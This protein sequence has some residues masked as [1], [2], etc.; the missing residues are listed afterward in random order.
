MMKNYFI[1]T[2]LL[3]F[4]FYTEAQ[5]VEIPDPY[6]KSYLIES[7]VD[8]NNDGEIQVSEAEVVTFISPYIQDP[9]T[10]LE[11]IQS[12]TS[13]EHLS[14]EKN[15]GDTS[16]ITEIDLSN[17]INLEWLNLFRNNLESIDLSNNLNLERLNLGG[18]S[19]SEID[20]SNNLDLISL[21]LYKMTEN[22]GSGISNL[23]L[24]ANINLQEVRVG[25]SNL[26][27]L[28]IQNGNNLNLQDLHTQSNPLLSCIQVDDENYVYPDCVFT[29]S[30][31]IGWCIETYT[32][33]SEDC[34]LNT[35]DNDIKRI[36]IIPNPSKDNMNI[37]SEETLDSIE[38]YDLN[39]KLIFEQIDPIANLD[40]SELSP[41]YYF[42]KIKISDEYIFKKLIKK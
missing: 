13:L 22:G 6:F 34:T 23:N 36:V 30:I 31:M 17:N 27:F 16:V 35:V 42:L 26:S 37:I 18:N 3:F 29:G 40:I 5:I 8:T 28:N 1:I 10:S 19:L 33:L 21:K 14:V 25:E 2:F 7:G 12:F 38:I 32:T 39:G 20:L 4:V 24:S 11:G 15:Y 41:G 9:I